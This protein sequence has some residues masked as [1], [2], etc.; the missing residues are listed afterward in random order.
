VERGCL[1][2]AQILAED[3]REERP[4][5]VG[6]RLGIEDE[7]VDEIALLIAFLHAE[8]G[9]LLLRDEPRRVDERQ[10]VGA[11]GRAFEMTIPP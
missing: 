7:M 3:P 6:E 11:A 8:R 10:D 4:V 9:F 1:L 5:D 2:G